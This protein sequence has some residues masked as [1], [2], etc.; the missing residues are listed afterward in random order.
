MLAWNNNPRDSRPHQKQ[1]R[2]ASG[3]S[4]I[5]ACHWWT[6]T[7]PMIMS[8]DFTMSPTCGMLYHLYYA[9][10]GKCPTETHCNFIMAHQVSHG[11]KP[12][13]RDQPVFMHEKSGHAWVC[14]SHQ[15]YPRIPL[16]TWQI[17]E[18]TMTK[19]EFQCALLLMETCANARQK[20]TSCQG[21]NKSHVMLKSWFLPCT[22][23]SL[24]CHNMF[25]LEM[26]PPLL[27]HAFAAH[28]PIVMQIML[29]SAA[30]WR[31][32]MPMMPMMPN[33]ALISLQNSARLI[34]GF[35]FLDSKAGSQFQINAAAGNEPSQIS[36]SQNK[37]VKTKQS[38]QWFMTT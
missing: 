11:S 35:Q 6:S 21:K 36:P 5:I 26:P 16:W 20:Q 3:T 10:H 18:H 1:R 28:L 38:N 22:T 4:F 15:A 7:W 2:L 31:S 13:V 23:K 17:T 14:H 8:W 32:V 30:T 37:A 27:S 33:M 34:S 9:T 24:I 29:E 19:D 25:D 12:M